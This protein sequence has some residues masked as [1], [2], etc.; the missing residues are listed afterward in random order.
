MHP[1]LAPD[2]SRCKTRRP[3]EGCELVWGIHARLLHQARIAWVRHCACPIELLL[4]DGSTGRDVTLSPRDDADGATAAKDAAH[5]LECGGRVWHVEQHEDQN[6][7]IEAGAPQ[8]ERL[9]I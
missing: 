9:C 4:P 1:R 6:G 7:D 3:Q 2:A 5:F 8:A